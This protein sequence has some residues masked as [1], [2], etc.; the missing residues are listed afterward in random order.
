[1]AAPAPDDPT[2]SQPTPAPPSGNAPTVVR[3]PAAGERSPGDPAPAVVLPDTGAAVRTLPFAPTK[4]PAAVGPSVPGYDILGEL[5]RGGMGVVYKARH[6]ALGRVVAL[7]MVLAG[8]Y[9]SAFEV[10][11]LNAEAVQ[12]AHAEHPN[13]VH[14]YDVGD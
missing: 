3:P 5:G 10:A 4:T 8:E 12:L 2:L 1:M 7:K 11:R 14:V 6:Q 13:I 9:A